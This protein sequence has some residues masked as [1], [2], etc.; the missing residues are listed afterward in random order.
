MNR[1][2]KIIWSKAKNAYVVTSEIAKSH[3]KGTSGKVVKASLA[4]AVGLGLLMGGYTANAVG[5]AITVEGTGSEVKTSTQFQG[6]TA[7]IYGAMN[8]I[9]ATA[10]D[11]PYDGVANS[12]VGAVNVTKN[13]NAA[14][15]FGAG[16]L[17]KN[18]YGELRDKDG[19]PVDLSAL[20]AELLAAYGSE[21]YAGVA[22]VLGNYVSKSGGSILAVGGGNAADWAK[23]SAIIGT[24]NTLTGAKSN[25]SSGNFIAGQ[26]NTVTT[27]S[28]EKNTDLK[29]IDNKVIGSENTITSS[30][31]QTVIGDKN[32]VTDRNVG[33]V[34]GKHD[35][36]PENVSDLVIGKGNKI[37][38]NDTYMKGYESLTVIGNNNTAVNP[39]ASIL[40][41]D[42]R[43]LSVT[44]E[45][46]TIGSMKPEE[47]DVEDLEVAN[48]TV[49][50]GYGAVA[51]GGMDIAIGH[52][53]KST[54]MANTV[55][56]SNSLIKSD[57]GG[58]SPLWSSVYG[59]FNAMTDDDND[60]GSFANSIVGTL[61]K[62]DRSTNTVALGSG[63]KVDHAFAGF[64][65]GLNGQFLQGSLGELLWETGH[66][67]T[68]IDR[69]AKLM[70]EVASE[71]GGSVLALGNGNTA[72]YAVRSQLT[73]TGNTLTGKKN[74]LSTNTTLTGF[75]NTGDNLN[76]VSVMGT[77]NQV[78]DSSASVVIGDY[79]EVQG[80]KN[81]VILGAMKTKE[82]PVDKTYLQQATNDDG[83]TLTGMRVPY[84]VK[85][86]VA[87]KKHM[88][89]VNNAV[90]LGYN[91]DVTKDGGVAL[92]SE[93]VASVD[94][95]VYGYNPFTGKKLESEAEIAR[96]S[97]KE[98]EITQ[99]NT[100]L[101]TLQSDYTAA[102]TDYDGKLKDYLS[103]SAEYTAAYQTYHGYEHSGDQYDLARKKAMDDAK[104]AMDAAKTA[105][106]SAQTAYATAEGK[107]TAAVATKN[108]ILGT[109]QANA[110]AVS[111]GDA[112]TG[113]TRQITNVAAGTEDT[114]AVNVAQLKA[115]NT[116]LT[117]G[118]LHYYSVK[119][120]EQGAG[121]N[122]AND[123][124]KAKDS[125]VI[126]INSVSEGANSTVIGN[127]NKLTG[128]KN[129]RNNSIVVGQNLTVDG[130]HN[131]VFGT[132][133]ANYDYKKTLV[134][135]EHNTVLG[136]GNLVG[137]TAEKDPNDAT[138]W[139]YTK[140]GSSSD[141]N[142]VV[143]LTNTANVGSVVVGTSSVADSLGTSL[144]H[145]NTIIGMNDGGGQRGVAIGNNLTVKGEE[146]VAIGTKAEATADWTL[147]M[148]SN[149]KAEKEQDMAIGY[150]A[151]AKGKYSMAFGNYSGAEE[152]VAVAMGYNAHAKSEY[153][154]ALG[155]LSVADR[156]A[157]TA[158]YDPSTKAASTDESAV[159]KANLGAVS[160]GDKTEGYTRQ[161][162]NVAAGKEDTDAVNV[163]QLKAVANQATTEAAKHTTVEAGDYVTV[164]ESTNNFGG[165]KYTVNGPAITSTDGTVKIEDKVENGKK[166]G[167]N[168]SVNTS[169]LNI[170][171]MHVK[172]G[173]VTY[174]ADGKGT[175]ELTHQ[176]GTKATVTGIKDTKLQTSDNALKL[177][178]KKL[179]MSVKDTA[180]NEVKG[181]VDLAAIA[182]E[183]DTNTTYEMTSTTDSA[184]NTTTIKLAG[185][186][187]DGNSV[188]EQT[189]TVATKDTRNTVKA[190]ENVS[191][192]EASNTLG[193]TE[194]T[195]NVK[196]DGKVEKGNTKIISGDTVYKETRVEKD[197]NYV[198]KDN[199][200]GQNLSALDKQVG[201]NTQN[202]TNNTK[203]INEL[204]GQVSNLDN[205]IS[206]VGAGAAALA[207]L[208]PLDFDP[209]DKWDI[210]AGFGNYR[211]A[212]AAAVGLFYRPNERTMFSLSATMG[213]DR[214]MFNAG[215]S[216]KLGSGSTYSGLSK[217]E[218]ADR[219]EKQGEKME[220]MESEIEE[221]KAQIA[222]LAAKK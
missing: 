77:G 67:D 219:L 156:A 152:Q 208:H 110:A 113:L 195:I 109:W 45:S 197:G 187:K 100:A 129:N 9:D 73:G 69:Y 13:A 144:G 216:V 60:N 4:A 170:K 186:D 33:T 184:N 154:V 63:N 48:G 32:S 174:D 155:S 132:D 8:Q 29:T 200:A 198:K 137:Y 193:G 92:G 209:H 104:D 75:R 51:H 121:S 96:L 30:S 207:A 150:E 44:S 88:E 220:K 177:D 157:G 5:Y 173:T 181:S 38:G 133:Y 102:K 146:A 141:Q 190:G 167:Y 176:D 145:G 180:G 161:I 171:D 158:G 90:M 80:G 17:V 135:G 26:G 212:S 160:V 172:E 122:Y 22:K 91:T 27:K 37:S 108:Q 114:D 201:T 130:A 126:G 165:T 70:G 89:N 153:G 35:V 20:Q 183:V 101:P 163:A 106:D 39:S 42:N 54:G 128:N 57:A 164:T 159:W 31:G 215:V 10:A 217:A 175:M 125:M 194:Y 46:V 116:K 168:L 196:A 213:D 178:G 95:G 87:A 103:K 166:V 53:T 72:D 19:N 98:A 117:S 52:N 182:G 202:I 78:K 138:K 47:R 6:A 83:S 61:N 2:Y 97:G 205:R 18:S 120:D 191:L 62:V 136:I 16:N 140:K 139:V 214:N 82:I 143:G 134:A 147:A 149:A 221:L 123:G 189:V 28:S 199:T 24:G 74:A 68:N 162:T 218:M 124:A 151:N 84:T 118:A 210:A 86:T 21:G 34:S 148:G 179:S 14:L 58:F 49:S 66:E 15:I 43:H 192:T 79:H 85:S 50:V 76:D 23:S 119:S 127:N 3:T 222:Q 25:V 111:V 40:I 59:S 99:I 185:K 41:G 112:A 93:S 64:G 1:I 169:K 12:I 36:R 131:A 115:L 81:N 204:G 105:M 7:S 206:K 94:K 142:V 55:V 56:G 65:D 203:M 71:S 188:S 11:K 107:Y 211:N